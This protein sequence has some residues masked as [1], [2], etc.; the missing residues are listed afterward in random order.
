MLLTVLLVAL[1]AACAQGDDGVETD[2]ATELVRTDP[3]DTVAESPQESET[4]TGAPDAPAE[5]AEGDESAGED[6]A[7]AEA[8]L[9]PTLEAFYQGYELPEKGD[10][11]AP[12]VLYEFA[13]YT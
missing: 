2:A 8:T 1:T 6:V 10:P 3:T 9:D 4:P 13:D 7:E 5:G 11:D 12:V